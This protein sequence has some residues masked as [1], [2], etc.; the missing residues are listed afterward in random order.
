MLKKIRSKK[1]YKSV[2][3]QEKIKILETAITDDTSDQRLINFLSRGGFTDVSLDFQRIFTKT[4]EKFRE[5][6]SHEHLVEIDVPA[7]VTEL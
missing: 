6:T 2:I 3:N 4:E 7:M 1:D 5:R